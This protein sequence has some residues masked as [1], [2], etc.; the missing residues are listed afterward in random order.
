M[1]VTKYKYFYLKIENIPYCE[2]E[3]GRDYWCLDYYKNKMELLD[4]DG[5]MIKSDIDSVYL[6]PPNTRTVH[7]SSNGKPFTHTTACFYADRKYMDSLNIPYMTP[8]HIENT[9]ELEQLMLELENKQLSDS[10]F[11]QNEQN[12]Y[13]ELIL[14]CLHDTIQNSTCNYSDDSGEDFHTLRHTMMNS[15][16]AFWTI[17][18]MAART[19]MS[20]SGFQRKYKKI[21]G[22][23]PIADLYDFRFQQ[24]K[25][26]LSTG[27]SNTYILNSC[28][29][30][31]LQH[32]SRFFKE[33]EGV[34]PSEYKKKISQK[35]ITKQK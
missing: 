11:K 32:F 23:S 18:A 29:F 27:Y 19:N 13:L 8:L 33:R 3:H 9:R 31:S 5:N 22:K 34:S 12:A 35:N 28:G 21:Y 1:N 20:V 17:E 6:I 2:H 26:L 14:M 16:G 24:A 25:K 30:K 10:E 15:P 7:K 4:S